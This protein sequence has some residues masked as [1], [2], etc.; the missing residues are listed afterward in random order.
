MNKLSIDLENCFG[1]G[2][3]IHEFDYQTN[4]SNTAVIYAP[5][6]TMKT[7]FA[8]TFDL[9]SKEDSKNLPCDRV[10]S[11]RITKFDISVDANPI[12]P[13]DI[14]VIN[15]ED[16]GFDASHRIYNFLASK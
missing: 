8:R 16:N 4:N 11:H 5:N 14:L 12:N 7:S 9:I 3:L 6:G 2:K 13:K 10:H 15:A 1:I